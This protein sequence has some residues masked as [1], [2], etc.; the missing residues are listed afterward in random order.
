MADLRDAKITVTPDQ[1]LMLSG[2]AAMHD[3]S[4]YKHQSMSWFSDD[5]ENWSEPVEVGE[6]R[7]LVVASYL[8]RRKGLW[9]RLPDKR[10]T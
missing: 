2:A 5:G 7:Q 4:H 10:F 1:R 6:R 3:T 9:S 8:A